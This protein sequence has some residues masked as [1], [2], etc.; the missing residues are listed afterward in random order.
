[1][2]ELQGVFGGSTCEREVIEL[3]YRRAENGDI[4]NLF[5]K[6]G[7]KSKCDSETRVAHKKEDGELAPRPHAKVVCIM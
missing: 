5:E 4:Q 3:I 6:E 1:M 7:L 2:K